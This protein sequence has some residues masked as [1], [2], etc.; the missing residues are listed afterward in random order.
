MAGS[1]KKDAKDG[2]LRRFRD[3]RWESIPSW[4][5]HALTPFFAIYFALRQFFQDR[6]QDVASVL[7]FTTALSLVPLLSVV[8]SALALFGT[9]DG[10]SPTLRSFLEQAFPASAAEAATYLNQFAQTSATSVGGLSA[11]AFLIVAIFLFIEIERSF[12]RIWNAPDDRRWF[13]KILTFYFIITVG[14]FLLTLSVGLSARAQLVLARLGIESALPVLVSFLLTFVLFTLTHRL[15][16]NTKVWWS[17]ALVGGLF[18]TIAFELGKWGFNI[19]V[20]EVIFESY[21]TI[22]GALGLFPIFLVWIY[23]SWVIVLI[24]AE[25]AY[26]VQHLRILVDVDA[27]SRRSPGRQKEHI[28]NPLV[29]LEI[30]APVARG[31]KNGEGPT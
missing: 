7:A 12:N 21:R 29:G 26:A 8:T 22:Y 15:L 1:K 20:N 18:T 27:A 25:L 13:H 19:Y 9:F 10:T 3:G 24:G 31:F 17:A 14:P 28:F 16:P 23:V 4:Q 5:F 2:V 30:L 11:A 6:A